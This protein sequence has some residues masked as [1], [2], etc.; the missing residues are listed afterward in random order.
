MIILRL[1]KSSQIDCPSRRSSSIEFPTGGT[2]ACEVAM[3]MIM[4]MDA[5]NGRSGMTQEELDKLCVNTLRFLAVDAV[6]HAKSGHPGLPLGAA[7]MAYVL[8]SRFLRHDPRDPGWW[9]RDRFVLSAGHGS[10]LLY[11][12]LHLFGY[13][14][15]LDELRR[16]RQWGSRTPG[17]PE[18]HL[19]P[20]VEAS[21]GPLGQG[22][23]NAVGMAI[24]EAHLAARYNRPG[25]DIFRHHTFALAGD[26]DLMEGVGAESASLA[27]HL[28]LGRLVVLYDN[29]HVTLSGTTSI[30]FTEDVAA[31]YGAYGWHVDRVTDGNDLTAIE[32]AIHGA[33]DERERPS[34]IMVDTVIGYGAPNKSGTFEAHG[35][36]LG[37]EETARTKQNLGWPA[38]PTFFIPPA[39]AAHVHDGGSRARADADAWRK[40]LDE[41]AREFPDLAAEVARRFEG[42]LP[43]HWSSGLPVF[44]AD[45]KGMATRKASEGV[46]QELA[47]TVPA[48]IGGSGD[49]DPSTFSWLK[50]DGDFEPE[51]TS[52][53]GAQG[54]AGGP[55]SYAGRNIHFGVRE[56]AMGAAVNGLA[57]HGGFIPFG[58]TF[59]VFSDYMRPAIRLAALSH[60]RSIFVFTHDSIGLGEDGPTHQAV[61]HLAALR[62]IPRLLV[63]RPGDANETRVAWQVALEARDRP[64]ALALTRQAVPTLDRGRY[65]DP[66]GLR[67][68]AYVLDRE[69]A[70]APAPQVILIATG[71]E[72][73]VAI[74][75][76]DQLRAD[77]MR[78][79][80]VSMPCWRLF[81]EQSRDYQD[82]VLPPAVTARV[83]VEAGVSFGWHRFVGR[84]GAV[85]TVDRF[86]ASAPGETVMREYGITPAHV[87]DA[88]RALLR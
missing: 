69:P 18:S 57:Y 83:A 36:P 70:G 77:G 64:T 1:M 27:G 78:V 12:L 8:W 23:A 10:A 55:W 71:S 75:A 35:S 58:A 65:A 13:D 48:L 2:V 67:R 59:L 41:Y 85:V 7:P 84:D 33:I 51:S 52:P 19:T 47:R 37:P 72:L 6:E 39:A 14:L 26:G 80:V 63:I 56:H 79:R 11:A 54:A 25:H 38:E 9:D 76:A 31:R 5:R 34:L 22:V 87:A 4:G 73:A 68:G 50:K 42:R 43:D 40:Q 82:A 46:L 15:P 66:E 24:G 88:A 17:H 49:L 86:G 61:E 60:L 44:A 32:R 21:T 20:G 62:A 53:A 30:T 28:R 29:N 74:A 81:E 16:F 45:A 3:T